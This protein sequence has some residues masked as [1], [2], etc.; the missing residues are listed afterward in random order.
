MK[1]RKNIDSE[2]YSQ[3]NIKF[4]KKLIKMVEEKDIFIERIIIDEKMKEIMSEKCTLIEPTVEANI[5]ITYKKD[6]VRL[7]NELT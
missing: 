3:Y 6:I 1:N 2:K 4:L 5:Q 7:I